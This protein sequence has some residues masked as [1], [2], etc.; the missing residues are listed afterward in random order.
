MKQK[1]QNNIIADYVFCFFKNFDISSAVW[2]LYMVYRG[3]P[4]WQ[5]GIVE[6]IFHLT[7]FLCEVP[8]GAMADLLGRK[9]VMIL[10]RILYAVAAIIQ[11][12]STNIWHFII[13]FIIS[14]VS[15]NLNSGSEEAL[16]YDS[17]KTLGKEEHYIK[18]NG[19]LNFLIEVSS[20]IATFVGGV[21][22]DYSYTLCY[23]CV[24]AVAVLA[25]LPV[26]LMTEPS[27]HTSEDSDTVSLKEHFRICK[28][29]LKGNPAIL[30]ILIYYP[31]VMTF[32]TVLFFYGQEYYSEAGF[33]RTGISIIMLFAA[34]ASC[35]GALTSDKLMSLLGEKTKYVSSLFMAIGILLVS[36][37][38][39]PVSIAGF[40]L[41]SYC[42][43]LLY[44]IQSATLN[45]LIPSEQ[46]ATII[47]IDSMIFSFAMVIFFPLCGLM[48][49]VLNLHIAFVILGIV[50]IGLI[51]LLHRK[52]C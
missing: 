12:F 5:I 29:I 43:S 26:C 4:L 11:L 51:G 24:I 1:L 2:V 46:R 21:L 8:S 32:Y 17:L 19:R 38:L 48:A 35:F 33:S 16:V 22:A 49:T 45:A 39:L 28:D 23:L 14:A 40:L 15:Y 27:I 41:S 52:N 36:V 44:P 3:L 9:R 47:S 42:N 50:Q 34:A 7:S 30:K 25:L 31:L 6:G 20:G 13:A 10:G 18:I 37:P